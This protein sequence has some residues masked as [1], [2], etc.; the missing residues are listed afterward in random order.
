[1]KSKL[2]R[3]CFTLAC[4]FSLLSCT[5]EFDYTCANSNGL[6]TTPCENELIMNCQS[7]AISNSLIANI[8]LVGDWH[9]VAYGCG[10]CSP[11]DDSDVQVDIRFEELKGTVN[12]CYSGDCETIQFEWGI[13]EN[14]GS[15]RIVT[16]PY[17]REV[18]QNTLCTNYLV[19]NAT[20]TDGS[21]MIFEKH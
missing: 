19:H 7:G 4:L 13:E 18:S 9:L 16:D 14:I 12:R 20:P 10:H 8:I 5:E 6:L 21:M 17:I 1:M 11:H 2:T 15:I 3:F